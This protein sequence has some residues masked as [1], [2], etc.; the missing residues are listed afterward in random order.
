MTK[1]YD[2]DGVDK[3]GN[4]LKKTLSVDRIVGNGGGK[5]VVTVQVSDRLT[6][7]KKFL[8]GNACDDRLFGYKTQLFTLGQVIAA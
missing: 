1:K 5:T 8:D 7:R 3:G 4:L 2:Y 6:A